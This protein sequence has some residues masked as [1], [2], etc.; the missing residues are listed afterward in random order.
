MSRVARRNLMLAVAL[1]A[2]I[3]AV[4]IIT[5]S[6]GSSHPRRGSAAAQTGSPSAA[7]AASSYLGLGLTTV[8][9]R[10]QNGETLAEIAD[11]TP[12]HS[13]QALAGAIVAERVAKLR[14]Q[15]ATPAE[16]A[17]AVR[18][19]R[20]RLRT[21]LRRKR[22]SGALVRSASRYLGIEE[23]ALREQLRSGKTLAQVAAAHGHSRQELVEGIL[24][25]RTLAL[26]ALRKRGQI[27]PAEVKRALSLLRA[28][29]VR[30]VEAKN[31]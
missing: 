28:K 7:Q 13:A 6:G 31:L 11:S 27:S 10:L 8:R 22:R 3:A 29:V 25:G 14:K 15:G 2:V 1:I 5:L 16:T 12:G 23:A 17:A 21:Q 24:R 4:L 30:V 19:L 20:A 9:R 26:E 18:K